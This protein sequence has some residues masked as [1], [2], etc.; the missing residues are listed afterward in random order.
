MTGRRKPPPTGLRS[1][2]VLCAEPGRIEVARLPRAPPPSR[3]PPRHRRSRG[4]SSASAAECWRHP[5]VRPAVHRLGDPDQRIGPSAGHV[6]GRRLP[7]H[8]LARTTPAVPMTSRD[9]HAGPLPLGAQPAIGCRPGPSDAEGRPLAL[10]REQRQ[11]SRVAGQPAVQRRVPLVGPAGR[12]APRP[13]R[14]RPHRAFHGRVSRTSASRIAKSRETLVDAV[15]ELS[16]RRCPRHPRWRCSSAATAHPARSHLRQ[17]P[18]ERL[19]TYVAISHAPIHRPNMEPPQ[20]GRQCSMACPTTSGVGIV[21][22]RVTGRCHAGSVGLTSRGW[23]RGPGPRGPKAGG[24]EKT[25][26]RAGMPSR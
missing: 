22:S 3:G 13:A 23:P 18:G 17:H 24:Y 2:E 16:G 12:A 10:G 25:W 19:I 7:C 11:R 1:D 20:V 6:Q 14:R 9:R 21:D 26:A 15:A 8:A 5:P 4:S